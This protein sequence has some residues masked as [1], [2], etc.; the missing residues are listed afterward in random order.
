MGHT[1]KN[2]GYRIGQRW[3]RAKDYGNFSG[4]KVICFCVRLY[5]RIHGIC[6]HS[7][8]ARYM[9]V[10]GRTLFICYFNPPNINYTVWG[11]KLC[12]F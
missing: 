1:K 10:P 5:F 11:I 2:S 3:F 6:G 4:K 8:K 9:E 12:L 7:K